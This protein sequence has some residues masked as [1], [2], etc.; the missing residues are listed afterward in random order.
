MKIVIFDLDDCLISSDAKIIVC[1]CNTNE[2]IKILS[3]S[4]FNHFM[5]SRKQYLNFSQFED[6]R[7]LENAR[8]YTS[9][10]RSFKRFRKTSTVGIITARQNKRI[11]LEFF[12]KKGLDLD[13]KYVFA[14]GHHSYNGDVPSRKKQALFKLVKMG[15]TSFRIYDDNPSNLKAFASLHENDII[16]KTIHV[17]H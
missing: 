17:R 4:Q 8:F 1:D 16:V 14:V 2:R 10:L 11:I 15:F 9:T 12:R 3:T 13:S 5:A 7:I 6:A